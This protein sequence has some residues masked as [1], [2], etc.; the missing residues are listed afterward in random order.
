MFT[1]NFQKFCFIL[2]SLKASDVDTGVSLYLHFTDIFWC[3]AQ[4]HIQYER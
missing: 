1:M 4:G 3:A 2:S